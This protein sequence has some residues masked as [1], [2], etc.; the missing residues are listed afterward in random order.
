MVC[1]YRN[2]ASEAN[3]VDER[4]TQFAAQPP[5]DAALASQ[6]EALARHRQNELRGHFH[7][8]VESSATFGNIGNEAVARQRT[9]FTV[10]L[11]DPVELSTGGIAPFN[12]HRPLTSANVLRARE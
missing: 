6:L 3:F 9:A 4:H 7:V 12:E 5:Y 2:R 10:K 8:D 1:E 11:R